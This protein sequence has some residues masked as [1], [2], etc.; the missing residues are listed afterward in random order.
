MI[1]GSLGDLVSA[2]IRLF[3]AVWGSYFVL[4]SAIGMYND[5]WKSVEFH[6]I[7]IDMGANII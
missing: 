4:L 1:L 2:R 7:D 3:K 5:I 6:C